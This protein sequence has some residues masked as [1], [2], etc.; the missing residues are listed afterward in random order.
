MAKR[1]YY[2]HAARRLAAK[3]YTN[4]KEQ[5]ACRYGYEKGAENILEN[6]KEMVL[7][8]PIK[9]YSAKDVIRSIEIFIDTETNVLTDDSEWE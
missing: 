1:N 9:H 2:Q 8:P 4:K 5:E 3:N 7:N 6:L